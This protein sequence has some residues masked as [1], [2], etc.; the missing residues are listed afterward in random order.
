MLN[1]PAADREH[2]QYNRLFAEMEYAQALHALLAWDKNSMAVGV[3]AADI[4]PEGFL[5][6]RL[7]FIGLGR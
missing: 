1:R 3:L 6:S 7:D 5:S 2:T 4:A